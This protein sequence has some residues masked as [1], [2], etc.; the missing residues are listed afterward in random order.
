MLSNGRRRSFSIASPPHASR[1]LELHV[2]RVP[3]GEFSER[4]FADAVSGTL[5]ELEGPLGHFV[6]QAGCAGAACC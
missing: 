5:L 1:P 3:G 2:R 6:Y 4:L